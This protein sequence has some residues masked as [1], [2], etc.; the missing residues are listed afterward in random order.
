MI[1]QEIPKVIHQTWKD[2]AV[3]PSHVAYQQS[4][5]THHPDWEYRLWSDADNRALLEEHY[6]WFLPIYDNYPQVIMRVDAIRYFILYHH[7]GLYVDLDFESL[8][9]IDSYLAQSTLVIGLEPARHARGSLQMAERP[10]DQ[11]LCNAFMASAPRHPFWE[12][13]FKV[14]VGMHLESYPVSATGPYMLTRAYEAFPRQGDIDLLAADLICPIA[15]G[16]DW[17]AFAAASTS[18]TEPASETIKPVAVHHWMATW[19][20]KDATPRRLFKQTLKSILRKSVSMLL[21]PWG[22]HISFKDATNEEPLLPHEV[23]RRHL[24]ASVN[25]T[26]LPADGP[27]AGNQI[28]FALLNSGQTIVR[29]ALD[30]AQMLRTIQQANDLPLISVLMETDGCHEALQKAMTLLQAQQN[31]DKEMGI[32]ENQPLDP[33]ETAAISRWLATIDKVRV[34]YIPFQRDHIATDHIATEQNSSPGWY[35]IARQHATGSYITLWRDSLLSPP[36]R[37]AL[38]MALLQHLQADVCL[39]QRIQLCQPTSGKLLVST[40]QMWRETGLYKKSNDTA[41]KKDEPGTSLPVGQ[42]TL[43][44]RVVIVDR[45]QLYTV[46]K[47]A[48]GTVDGAE[49]EQQQ[50]Q[51]TACYEGLAYEAMLQRLRGLFHLDLTPWLDNTRLDNTR[52]D[53]R[54]ATDIS[55]TLPNELLMQEDPPAAQKLPHPLPKILIAASVCNALPWLPRYLANLQSL[56]YPSHLLTLALIDRGSKDGTDAWLAAHGTA[57]KMNYADV[58]LLQADGGAED[59]P[60]WPPARQRQQSAT[61][62]QSHNLLLARALTDQTWVLWLDV[63]CV[64]TPK[65]VIEQL[66]G[67]N[68]EIVTAHAVDKDGQSVDFH[69]FQLKPGTE[70]WDWS[71]YILDGILQPPIG[72]G[73]TYLGDIGDPQCAELTSVGDQQCA[74][75]TSVGDAALLVKAELHRKGLIFPTVP[76]NYHIGSEGLAYLA[77]DMGYRCWGLPSLQVYC[78]VD[79]A[80]QQ[81]PHSCDVDGAAQQVAHSCDLNKMESHV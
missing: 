69:S 30:E 19:Q 77:R 68:R 54:W 50:K 74:E 16:E 52:L 4:W 32:V 20:H 65:D 51:A 24:A 13:L 66:V 48:E 26:L 56:T 47:G 61:R 49:F 40:R 79:G 57:A 10:F 43:P 41:Q 76:H 12:H 11:V 21:N 53:D 15:Y 38:Q 63:Q 64:H 28:G 62:A 36:N 27:G 37:L 22:Y 31:W 78:D 75:L 71:P 60:L 80:A 29:G 42:P 8:R 9:P 70:Q 25:Q 5:L 33:A 46:L 81:V 6:A 3:P 17:A 39:I 7:G 45:P 59:E 14:L 58:Q 2:A 55:A 23:K 44:D 18:S 72:H 34:L 1:T 67:A 35:E 73:R